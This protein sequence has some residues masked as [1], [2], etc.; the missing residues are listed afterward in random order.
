MDSGIGPFHNYKEVHLQTT[1]LS[2]PST[3][4]VELTNR[5]LMLGVR[6]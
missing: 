2:R 1:S 6:S 4:T 3:E 5:L